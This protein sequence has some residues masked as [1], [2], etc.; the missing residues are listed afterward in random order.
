MDMIRQALGSRKFMLILG[1]VLTLLASPLPVS[2]KTTKIVALICSYVLGQGFV[3]G[4]EKHG[5]TKTQA[6]IDAATAPPNL[7]PK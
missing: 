5:A 6:E 1:G 2:E 4:M 7:P 3:D